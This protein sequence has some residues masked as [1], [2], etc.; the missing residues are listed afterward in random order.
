MNELE[1]KDKK[2]LKD[3]DLSF[4]A[5][6]DSSGVKTD[7][8]AVRNILLGELAN[9]RSSIN[10]PWGGVGSS[11]GVTGGNLF[12]FF[13]KQGFGAYYQSPHALQ[14]AQTP[15]RGNDFG[16]VFVE[17]DNDT[18]EGTPSW[19]FD[20]PQWSQK[21]VFKSQGPGLVYD[22]ETVSFSEGEKITGGTSGATAS[23]SSVFSDM[24]NKGTLYIYSIVGNFHDGENITGDMGGSA[25]ITRMTVV[26]GDP[27]VP[28]TFGK[29]RVN[30]IQR[31]YGVG[32]EDADTPGLIYTFWGAISNYAPMDFFTLPVVLDGTARDVELIPAFAQEGYTYVRLG[33]PNALR[34]Y[35]N[36]SWGDVGGGGTV[37]VTTRTQDVSSVSATVDYAHGLGR[38]PKSVRFQTY[39][40]SDFSD[41]TWDGT[42]QMGLAWGTHQAQAISGYVVFITTSGGNICLGKVVS[43][44]A[45]NVRVSYADKVGAPT[46]TANIVITAT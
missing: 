2:P 24:G 21:M 17:A 41:G 15:V 28:L 45:T 6:D 12:G 35:L 43:A 5:Q 9:F 29:P 11:S 30:P 3:G 46:G 1:P 10:A 36:G 19:S 13:A 16:R 37:S 23:I 32:G 20:L 26:G 33:T 25:K 42:N 44:D 34:I 8:E 18:N 31:L 40:G 27:A 4:Y 7:R 38:T 22:T 14:V 39:E